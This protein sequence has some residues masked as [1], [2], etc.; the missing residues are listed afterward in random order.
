M[1]RTVVFYKTADGKCPVQEFLDSLSARVVQKVLWTLKLLEDLEFLPVTYFKKLTG[2][3]GIWECRVQSGSNIYR[4]F[5]FFDVQSVVILTHGFMKKTQK[6]PKQ[7]IERAE[8]LKKDYLS[9]R[10]KI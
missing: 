9:R 7:E 3:D 4:I 5:C 8:A 1:N 6:T 2:S 10:K